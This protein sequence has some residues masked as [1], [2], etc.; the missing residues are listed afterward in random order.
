MV[1]TSGGLSK[2]TRNKTNIWLIR[3]FI[4]RIN[5]NNVEIHHHQ[6][7]KKSI[8]GSKNLAACEVKN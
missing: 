3:K 2:A 4:I 8:H 7:Q 1:S 5:S 6:I